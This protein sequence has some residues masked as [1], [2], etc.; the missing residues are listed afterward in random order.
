MDGFAVYRVYDGKREEIGQFPSMLRAVDAA[1]KQIKKDITQ[2]ETAEYCITRK[3]DG[4]NGLLR[5][6][7]S[8]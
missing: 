7:S 6:G 5:V 4:S 2:G 3:G 1:E 8:L